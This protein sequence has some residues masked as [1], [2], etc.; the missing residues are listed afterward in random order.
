MI[1]KL[2]K[3]ISTLSYLP[4]LLWSFPERRMQGRNHRNLTQ[5]AVWGM[6]QPALNYIGGTSHVSDADKGLTRA[7]TLAEQ[8]RVLA[9]PT[10]MLVLDQLMQGVQ[11]NCELS[12]RLGLASNL[13]SHHL[14]VLQ[15]A[16]LVR[17]ERDAHDGRWIYY[18]VDVRVLKEWV[19]AVAAFLDAGRI[20]P[21]RP[22]CGPRASSQ[23]HDQEVPQVGWS[24]RS[25]WQEYT[26]HDQGCASMIDS[27]Q[28]GTA[29]AEIFTKPGCPYC[30]ALK[31]KL[32]HDGT[33]YV[34]HD[35]QGD[36]QAR[37][38]MMD[39]NGGRREVP[40]IVMGD[41]VMVGFHGTWTV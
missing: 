40:T 28:S 23:P 39:L 38:R 4:V 19:A 24:G 21:R 12:D 5:L 22:D 32:E 7:E 10:R 2:L 26:Q 41:Q 31:R 18:S 25:V 9:D 16:H 14:S 3:Q 11:C 35:V 36:P 37:R 1:P 33:R 27:E 29:P 17:A 15:E 13:V 8:L 34:E 6:F 20:Q 30:R